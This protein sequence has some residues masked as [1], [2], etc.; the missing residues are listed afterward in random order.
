MPKFISEDNKEFVEQDGYHHLHNT[1]EIT[2]NVR[3]NAH[4]PSSSVLLSGNVAILVFLI[5]AA[6]G[7]YRLFL[8]STPSAFLSNILMI[9][10]TVTAT[11]FLV[12]GSRR[13]HTWKR[14]MTDT[15]IIDALIK[16]GEVIEGRI[17]AVT[18]NQLEFSY[19]DFNGKY[20]T[21]AA[22]KFE[23]GDIIVILWV[24]GIATVVL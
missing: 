24:R 10:I 6:I 20:W 11:Y 21:D 1:S 3:K 16:H 23:V 7:I 19:E 4:F 22:H 8:A 17:T 13:I 14:T 12:L 5:P 15:E 18:E 2:L 9:A